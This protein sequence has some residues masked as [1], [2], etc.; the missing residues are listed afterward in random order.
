MVR[1]SKYFG[2][3]FFAALA[4]SPALAA[5]KNTATVDDPAYT[6]AQRL[7]EIEPGRKLNLYCTGTGSP[8]VVFDSGVT[9]ETVG[10][11]FVQPAIAH[12]R[13]HVP[14]IEPASVSAIPGRGPDRAQ[15][16]STIC[17][18]C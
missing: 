14:T 16:S 9:G 10:W 2:I 8:T 1:A 5:G 4:S 11:A 7:V 3:I 18:G 6:H 17:T 15:I 12:M 13:A